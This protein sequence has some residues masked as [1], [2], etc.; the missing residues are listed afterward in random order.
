MTTVKPPAKPTASALIPKLSGLRLSVIRDYGI[1]AFFVV[2]V[3][4]LSASSTAFFTTANMLN[5]LYQW[6]PTLILAAASTIVFIAGG[7]DLSIGSI[8]G[9]AGLSAVMLVPHVGVTLALLLGIGSGVLCGLLNGFLTTAGRINPFIATLATMLMFQGFAYWLSKGNLIPAS[10]P[11]FS[12][13]GTGELLGVPYAVWICVV[14]V[15]FCGFLLSRT[16][17][18]RAVFASGGNPEAAR[19]SGINV[20]RVRLTAF[21]L[22]GAAAALAGVLVASRVSTGQADAGGLNLAFNALTGIFLGGTSMAGGQGAMWR[23][24]LGI[25]LLALIGNWFNLLGVDATTQQIVQGAIILIAIAVD[26]WAKSS[27]D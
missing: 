22:S 14:F 10:D 5:I 19:L 13:L 4:V 9:L 11:A 16:T 18:G 3:V 7:F 23:T 20:N 21:V 6:S 27:Q 17:F 2:L 12:K 8:F 24:V 25:L 15:G 26:A 1:V